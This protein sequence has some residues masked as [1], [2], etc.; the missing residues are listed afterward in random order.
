MKLKI[1]SILTVKDWSK[2]LSIYETAPDHQ[3]PVIAAGVSLSEM[4]HG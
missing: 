2:I 1:F 4:A 3:L